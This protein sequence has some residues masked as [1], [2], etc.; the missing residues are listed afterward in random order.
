MWGLFRIDQ[1]YFDMF[2]KQL[3][4]TEQKAVLTQGC[5]TIPTKIGRFDIYPVQWPYNIVFF[6][7]F[8]LLPSV[9][10][11]CT[12]K[13]YVGRELYPYECVLAQVVSIQRSPLS[14]FLNANKQWWGGRHAFASMRERSI[15]K[16]QTYARRFA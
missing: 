3:S 2:W 5:F 4:K 1:Q 10:L 16:N 8:K 13:T 6:P 9:Q 11:C 14:F 7:R 12:L 15:D